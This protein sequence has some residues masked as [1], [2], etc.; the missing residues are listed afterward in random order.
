VS[1][2]EL[3]GVLNPDRKLDELLDRMTPTLGEDRYAKIQ[4]SRTKSVKQNLQ[5][6][7][8]D[9]CCINE[10]SSAEL[11]PAWVDSAGVASPAGQGV[12]L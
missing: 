12:V 9:T 1:Y 2:Q 11:V 7:W 4:A 3:Q 6:I 10:D 5:W 8:V